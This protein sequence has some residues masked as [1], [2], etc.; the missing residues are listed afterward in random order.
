MT[1][2]L[3]LISLMFGTSAFS[4]VDKD[5]IFQNCALNG[6]GLNSKCR[7]A[8]RKTVMSPDMFKVKPEPQSKSENLE[9]LGCERTDAETITCADGIYVKSPAING[10]EIIKEVNETFRPS[11]SSGGSASEQ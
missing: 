10:E 8:S 6:K 9:S 11:G 7:P 2:F 4:Q 5:N 3:V 1:A